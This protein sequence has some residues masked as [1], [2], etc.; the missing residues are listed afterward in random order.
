MDNAL[1]VQIGLGLLVI[2]FF[3]TIAFSV[4][5]WR[6]A[7]IFFL[8]LCFIGSITFTVFAAM[9]LKTHASWRTEV[10]TLS[11]DLEKQLAAKENIQFGDVT[12]VLDQEA[13]L[14]SVK[15]EIGRILI[16]RG[17]VWNNCVPGNFDGTSV[18]VQTA[19]LNPADGEAVRPNN[20][21]PQAVL[22]LF[23]EVVNADG[24]RVPGAYLGEFAA[25]AVTESSVTLSPTIPLDDQQLAAIRA[26]DAPAWMIYEILPIDGH[27]FFEGLTRDQL[28]AL[29][30]QGNIPQAN[31]DAM[32][33]AYVRNGSPAQ[34][35]D[36]PE[37]IWVKVKFVRKKSVTVDSPN[38]GVGELKFFDSD[39]RSIT[40]RLLRGETVEFEIGDT[41]ILDQKT[42]EQWIAAGDAE[43]Q[44]SIFLRPLN[45]YAL[46]YHNLFRDREMLRQTI[47]IVTRD[48]ASLIEAE[49]LCMNQIQARMAEKAKLEADLAQ[50]E[51]EQKQLEQLAAALEGKSQALRKQLQETYLLNQQLATELARL[52]QDMADKINQQNTSAKVDAKTTSA[53]TALAR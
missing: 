12:K 47:D 18:T 41:A 7:H 50:F 11:A 6:F 48:T 15:A 51:A 43:A 27:Q 32:I 28:V 34:P 53:K 49:K 35:D 40:P 1:M 20:I 2:F 10:N 23:K 31:Y 22:H 39:G 14:R 24:F 8:V 16:D 13:N 45:D 36:A 17:R 42:A 33:E 19:P 25:T 44:E 52:Q 5:T 9:T 46:I 37:D 3:V 30:P 21:E 29:M 4:R 26:N 38:I